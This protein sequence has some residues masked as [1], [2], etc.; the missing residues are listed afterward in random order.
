MS[1]SDTHFGIAELNVIKQIFIFILFWWDTQWE[2][3]C[4]VRVSFDL[5]FAMC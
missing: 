5:L 2:W 3:G 4:R 1:H